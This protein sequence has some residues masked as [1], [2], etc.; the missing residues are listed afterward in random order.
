MEKTSLRTGNKN[1]ARALVIGIGR[2]AVDKMAGMG[3]GD[4]A[5]V[6]LQAETGEKN[7]GLKGSQPE[8]LI[9]AAISDA[10]NAGFAFII[11]SLEEGAAIEPIAIKAAE[12]ARKRS[13][14]TV[15]I[16][17][18][19]AEEKDG[20]PDRALCSL[21]EAL[22]ALVVLPAHGI[23]KMCEDSV[24]DPVLLERTAELLRDA[25]LVLTDMFVPKEGGIMEADGEGLFQK[26]ER[27]RIGFGRGKKPGEE[28][29][30][31]KEATACPLLE[32]TISDASLIIIHIRG[33]LSVIEANDAVCYIQERA[34]DDVG[35]VFTAGPNRK[36]EEGI[37]VGVLTVSEK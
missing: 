33:S 5:F 8:D 7:A 21:E 12:F 22:D 37:H 36:G 32:G 11:A 19:P 27:L 9:D 30:A 16:I 1:A 14:Q 4:Y 17:A 23:R 25:V 2:M 10:D 28:E 20:K 6:T 13:L 3:S 24:A 31:A 29:N 34:G 18:A 15:G 35:I 26:G